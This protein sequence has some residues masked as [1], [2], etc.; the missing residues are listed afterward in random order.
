MLLSKRLSFVPSVRPRISRFGAL[1][2]SAI[3]C[4][5]PEI[6]DALREASVPVAKI[7]AVR[8]RFGGSEGLGLIWGLTAAP[9][10]DILAI[11]NTLC[12]MRGGDAA[13]ACVPSP[14][15]TV[16]SD[17]VPDASGTPEA[18][19]VASLWGKPS[20]ARLG[21]DGSLAWRFDAGYDGMGSVAVHDGPSGRVVLVGA[22]DSIVALDYATGARRSSTG[23]GRPMLSADWSGDTRRE[24]LHSANDTSFALIDNAGATLASLTVSNDFWWE[25]VTTPT[26]RPYLVLSAGSRLEVY[27][28]LLTAVR[29]FDATGM[30]SPMHVVGAAFLGD[31][32]GAPFV[33]VYNGRGAWH[34][35]VLYVFASD[36]SLQYQEVLDGDY[37]VVVPRTATAP[38][39]F[40]LSGRDEVLQFRFEGLQ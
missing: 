18:L 25:P 38:G 15:E 11:G 23:K 30:A 33:A 13:A 32:P 9:T 36:G 4:T 24:Y 29:T 22:N 40:L 12:T 28:S 2:L 21:M 27:D 5:T 31:G 10:G 16:F 20:A 8:T 7:V 37:R 14:V 17:A 26:R 39:S 35:S 3:G 1:M 19:I 6:P 34:R